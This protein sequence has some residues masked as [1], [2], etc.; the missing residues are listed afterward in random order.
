MAVVLLV[1]IF[2]VSSLLC[3]NNEMNLSAYNVK[4]TFYK[5]IY[6]IYIT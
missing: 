6:I 3:Q 4:I 1:D 5:L 2:K